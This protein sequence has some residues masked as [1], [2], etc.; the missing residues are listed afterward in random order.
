MK[1]KEF[2]ILI[3]KAII[4]ENEEIYRELFDTTDPDSATD[5]Y[6]KRA[7]TLY[8]QLDEEAREILLEIVKQTMKDTISNVFGLLDGVNWPESQQEGYHLQT[9]SG[10]EGRINGNLQDIF[11]QMEEEG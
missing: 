4:D 7:L 8:N 6:W 1:S 9:E 3:R 11:L 5:E 2:V 10:R